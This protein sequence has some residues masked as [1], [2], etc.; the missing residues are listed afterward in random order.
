MR[1]NIY[2]TL[3]IAL[4]LVYGCS[5]KDPN[6]KV[7]NVISKDSRITYSSYGKNGIY[8]FNESITTQKYQRFSVGETDKVVIDTV[9]TDSLSINDFENVTVAFLYELE[10]SIQLDEIDSNFVYLIKTRKERDDDFDVE[11]KWK[12][13]CEITKGSKAAYE[14]GE[15]IEV[16][17]MDA[18]EYNKANEVLY[19]A[20][21]TFAWKNAN[22]LGFYYDPTKSKVKIDTKKHIF[23]INKKKIEELLDYSIDANISLVKASN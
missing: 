2:S 9:F 3:V 10:N 15:T 19:K 11:D 18:T 17:E 1:L 21:E 12:I 23:I 20:K 7:N 13:K 22:S 5:E 6:Y 16:R 8:T 4:I 14:K